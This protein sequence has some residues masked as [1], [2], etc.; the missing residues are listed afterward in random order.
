MR[1][2]I[3][4]I[5]LREVKKVMSKN[6]LRETVAGYGGDGG[7]RY[8]YYCVFKC[9]CS[10]CGPDFY[11]ITDCNPANDPWDRDPSCTNNGL[12]DCHRY[13]EFGVSI[14]LEDW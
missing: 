1:K 11:I 6:E 13:G 14:P 10:P 2:K 4:R 9:N 3:G 5:N 8:Y 12:R 7:I